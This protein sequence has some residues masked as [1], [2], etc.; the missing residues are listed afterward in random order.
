MPAGVRPVVGGLLTTGMLVAGLSGCG[1]ATAA[2]N[3][4]TVNTGG[5][6]TGWRQVHAGM[7]TFQISNSS[8]GGAEVNLINPV[9]GAI[10]AEVDQVGPGTTV[11]MRVDLGSGRYAFRC[12]IED[13]DAI[14][15]P[16]VRIGGHR[17]GAPAVLPVTSTDLLAPAREYHAYVTAGLATLASQVGTLTGLIRPATSVRPGGPGCPRT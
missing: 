17:L 16:A 8:T 3:V 6:G 12:L 2:G 10:Y 13:T 15:G 9:N 11:P 5:C 1:T 7:Q 4:I 14:T